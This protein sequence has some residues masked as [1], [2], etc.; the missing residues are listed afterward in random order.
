[1]VSVEARDRMSITTEEPE[2]AQH[3]PTPAD[4]SDRKTAL[5]QRRAPR[6]LTVCQQATNRL[7]RRNWP[8]STQ[9]TSPPKRS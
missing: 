8:L 3:N 9:F 1:M 6:T 4:R 7:R 5:T 2:Q